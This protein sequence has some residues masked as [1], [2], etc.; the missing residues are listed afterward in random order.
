MSLG[1]GSVDQRSFT[2]GAR[3]VAVPENIGVPEPLFASQSNV[4]IFV[5]SSL[6]VTRTLTRMRSPTRM[7]LWNERHMFVSVH[8]GPGIF[9]LKSPEM[10][11]AHHM[12]GPVGGMPQIGRASCTERAQ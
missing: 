5:E 6:P 1:T 4:T 8:P 2:S 7:R 3:T 9:M 12:L 10:R 11:E